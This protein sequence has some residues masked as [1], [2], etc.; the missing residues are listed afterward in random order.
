MAIFNSYFDITRGLN[1]ISRMRCFG[2]VSKKPHRDFKKVSS[3]LQ[4]LINGSEKN[5]RTG[6]DAVE[7]KSGFIVCFWWSHRVGQALLMVLI[8]PNRLDAT[9]VAFLSVPALLQGSR[10]ITIRTLSLQRCMW[11]KPANLMLARLARLA[12]MCT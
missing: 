12:P 2:D 1:H 9:S 8:D 3:F 7:D 10:R 5:H 6:T 11:Q 4:A